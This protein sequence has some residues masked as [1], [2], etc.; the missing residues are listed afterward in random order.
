MKVLNLT[1]GFKPFES[2]E[3][4]SFEAFIFHGGEPHFKLLTNENNIFSEEE[5]E[6][7]LITCRIG[8]FEHLGILLLSVDAIRRIFPYIE[9]S[10]FLPYFP[11]ARQDRAPKGEALTAKI[12]ADIINNLFLS[13]VLIVDPHSDVAT[14]LLNNCVVIT[15]FFFVRDSLAEIEHL[16]DKVP[17]LIT[18][19]A[20]ASKRMWALQ[21]KLYKDYGDIYLTAQGS[22]HRDMSTGALSGFSID[23]ED[24]EQRPC[25]IIDDI[26]DGGGTFLGLA[27]ELKKS[28]A[29]NLYLIAT[30]G[31]FSKGLRELNKTFER[32][33]TTDSIFS[34]E[35][36]KTSLLY[37]NEMH[38][39]TQFKLS[40]YV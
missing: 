6:E 32:M 23:K 22:K 9:I 34:V 20:G 11:G 3:E 15:N 29:G 8:N 2:L 18:P 25:V 33:Y 10:L 37:D 26:C 4:L 12:Y 40:N 24:F 5:E 38:K 36:K 7:I 1:E 35:D 19:D 39:L 16:E 14:A 13:R 30:H 31:I 21:E 17:Y 28:D 27:K